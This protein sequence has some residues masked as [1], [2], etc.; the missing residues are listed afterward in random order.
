M[1]P[2]HEYLITKLNAECNSEC[3]Y[4]INDYDDNDFDALPIE[5]VEK[6]LNNIQAS[7]DLGNIEYILPFGKISINFITNNPV[8]YK[9]YND[10]CRGFCY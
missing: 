1:L 8:R 3:F 10:K 4:L 5:E 6:M 9:L 7:P 2:V